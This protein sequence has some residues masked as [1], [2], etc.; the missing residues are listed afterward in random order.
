MAPFGM[1]LSGHGSLYPRVFND[2]VCIFDIL[3]SSKIY[4][5]YY[6][7]IVWL[8]CI[9]YVRKEEEVKWR[10]YYNII[11]FLLTGCFEWEGK[12]KRRRW[13]I[14]FS[15]FEYIY[16]GNENVMERMRVIVNSLY[17]FI[18]FPS[19][20]GNL[21]NEK[22]LINYY[23]IL[24]LSIICLQCTKL[25]CFSLFSSFYQNKSYFHSFIFHHWLF[26]Q[27]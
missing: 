9:W 14:T 23:L 24:N 11:L 2:R 10:L 19:N 16:K 18:L 6:K 3:Y 4:F 8:I 22:F 26:K 25:H 27:Q 15:L 12:E 17:S 21:G 7:V 1:A 5:D 20:I 13:L